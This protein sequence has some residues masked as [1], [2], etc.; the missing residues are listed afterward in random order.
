MEAEHEPGAPARS[1]VCEKSARMSERRREQ[2]GVKWRH[3]VSPWLSLITRFITP[4]QVADPVW[5]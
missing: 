2:G 4:V 1:C 3:R 5:K